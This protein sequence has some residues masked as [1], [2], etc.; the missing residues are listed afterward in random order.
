M[1]KL[2]LKRLKKCP[3][4]NCD[5][6]GAAKD[7]FCYHHTT[8]LKSDRENVDYDL[9]PTPSKYGIEGPALGVE[10]ECYPLNSVCNILPHV[11]YWCQ[12]GSLD[13][14]GR[15]IKICNTPEKIGKQAAEIIRSVRET[16][17]RVTKGCGLH[18]HMSRRSDMNYNEAYERY[19]KLS[20]SLRDSIWEFFPDRRRQWVANWL[21]L[22]SRT[23]EN[24]IHPATLNEHAMIAWIDVCKKLQVVLNTDD[25][26]LAKLEKTKD[27]LSIFRKNSYASRYLRHRLQKPFSYDDKTFK[28]V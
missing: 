12:D 27:L 22:K 10:I 20:D 11:E 28:L 3:A 2:T 25:K 9:Y 17:G 8:I 13:H 14:D 1:S 18:V 24:R 15:E 6:L 5:K 7:G 4:D 26:S 19:Y 23:W 21:T 16:G